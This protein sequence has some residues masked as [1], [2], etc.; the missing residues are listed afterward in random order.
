MHVL[1]LGGWAWGHFYVTNDKCE[2]EE[3]I[4]RYRICCPL[5]CF[6]KSHFV[7]SLPPFAVFV[8]QF[9]GT[10]ILLIRLSHFV[11]FVVSDQQNGIGHFQNV[12]RHPEC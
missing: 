1:I 5:C 2:E 7:V 9:V 12:I 4:T 10:P 11:D 8:A 6:L 3:K